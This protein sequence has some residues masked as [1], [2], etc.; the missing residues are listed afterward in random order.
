MLFRHNL[1]SQELY[2][3]PF[4]LFGLEISARILNEAVECSLFSEQAIIYESYQ[5]S[6]FYATY[7]LEIQ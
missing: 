2:I 7:F 6:D 5:N 3:T 1:H 4:N